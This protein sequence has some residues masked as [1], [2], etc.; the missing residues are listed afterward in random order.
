M[1]S[2][3][4]SADTPD[5]G[6]TG[7]Q[8]GQAGA[9]RRTIDEV[10]LAAAGACCCGALQHNPRQRLSCYLVLKYALLLIPCCFQR[11]TLQTPWH[12]ETMV[13]T[14]TTAQHRLRAV[15]GTTLRGLPA[16]FLARRQSPLTGQTPYGAC[17]GPSAPSA[18]ACACG[19]HTTR[20]R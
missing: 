12:T 9:R 10:M 16:T 15:A 17:C 19:F 7:A 3:K 2:V 4:P 5:H 18:R 11:H 8:M 14:A 13:I 1:P 6:T 20:A